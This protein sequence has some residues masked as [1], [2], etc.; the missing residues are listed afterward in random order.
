MKGSRETIRKLLEGAPDEEIEPQPA[1]LWPRFE[2]VR[3]A[4]AISL[5]GSVAD[6]YRKL[7]TVDWGGVDS[8][9]HGH[10]GK[11]AGNVNGVNL[12]ITFAGTTIDSQPKFEKETQITF[13]GKFISSDGRGGIVELRV[14]GPENYQAYWL[15]SLRGH[16]LEQVVDS[17]GVVFDAEK[18][19]SKGQRGDKVEIPGTRIRLPRFR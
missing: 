15:E 3:R 10:E 13:R 6:M 11:L 2:K 19:P 17:D 1:E 5:S 7:E 4:I 18:I 16:R 14:G 9:I 8:R 12:D